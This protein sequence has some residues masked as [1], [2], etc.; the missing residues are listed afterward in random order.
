[1]AA[2]RCTLKKKEGRCAGLFECFPNRFSTE[3]SAD[4]LEQVRALEFCAPIL[5]HVFALGLGSGSTWLP[6]Q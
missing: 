3:S 5:V 6:T 2:G 4:F 1:M